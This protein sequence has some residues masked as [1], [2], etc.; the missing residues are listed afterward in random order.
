M[1]KS[2]LSLWQTTSDNRCRQS[3]VLALVSSFSHSPLSLCLYFFA[4][5]VTQHIMVRTWSKR[6]TIHFVDNTHSKNGHTHR[7]WG[8][9]PSDD[10]PSTR[11]HLLKV[12]LSSHSTT[13]W[14]T[15]RTSKLYQPI[16]PTNLWL[17]TLSNIS[18][19]EIV[20]EGLRPPVCIYPRF[21][22]VTS[23]H[24]KLLE[25]CY[26]G[27]LTK[28]T[29]NS[30]TKPKRQFPGPSNWTKNKVMT[31]PTLEQEAVNAELLGVRL[32]FKWSEVIRKPAPL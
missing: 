16:I 12:P 20:S 24:S 32:I 28:Q 18:N 13:G 3:F 1:V 11:L 4:C 14:D 26:V 6:K 29:T 10:L 5:V 21:P 19:K 15:E 17:M 30:Q 22:V 23:S 9:G 8:S 27:M 31:R 7:Y 25:N 2:F